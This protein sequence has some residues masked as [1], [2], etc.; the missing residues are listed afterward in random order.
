VLPGY[1]AVIVFEPTGV[2]LVVAAHD[3]VVSSTLTRVQ[4]VRSAAP[5]RTVTVPAAFPGVTRTV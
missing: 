2:A 5:A 1:E 4:V 3:A